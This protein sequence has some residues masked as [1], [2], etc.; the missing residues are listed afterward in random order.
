MCCPEVRYEKERGGALNELLAIK[1]EAAETEII[2]EEQRSK[3][4]QKQGLEEGSSKK[5]QQKQGLL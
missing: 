4:K 2:L 5:N 1:Q 3:K